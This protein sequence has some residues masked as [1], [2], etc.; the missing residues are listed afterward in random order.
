MI[1]ISVKH[2]ID[3][4]M[5]RLEAKFKVN[6]PRAAAIAL[7]ESLVIAKDAVVEEMRRVFDRPTPWTLNSM[8]VR[9][10]SAATNSL[11]ARCSCWPWQMPK[12]TLP[13]WCAAMA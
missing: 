3:A 11:P 5:A 8:R 13:L 2:N 7:N 1:T 6:V 10:A 4:V 9:R 12:A